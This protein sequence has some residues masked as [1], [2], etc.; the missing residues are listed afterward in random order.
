MSKTKLAFSVPGR[1]ALAI[2]ALP[3]LMGAARAQ[4]AEDFFKKAGRL[5]M[6]VS[7]D[8]GGG[9]EQIGRF[10]ASN[11]SRFL[12]GHPS[13]V[14]ENMPTAIGI[15][16]SNFFYNSAPR[17]GSAILADTNSALALPIFDS[18]AAHYDPR[19]FEWIGS[20]GK[21]QAICVT[22]KASE[23]VTLQDAAKRE[24]TVSTS[25]VNSGPGVYP[26]IL[27]SLLGTK[28]KVIAGYSPNA[29]ILAVDR[30]EVG[31]LC[32][33][34]WESFQ[35]RGSKWFVDK[36]VNVLAQIGISKSLDLPDVPLVE[37]LLKNPDDK[38]MLNLIVLPQEFGRPFVAPPGTPA[39]RM[40][41][42][43]RAFQAMVKDP[44]FLA[45]AKSQRIIIEPRDDKEIEAL[46]TQAYTAPK[47][48]H[49]RAAA[50]AAQMD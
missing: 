42:Y 39:D 16:A 27:N 9:Y 41:T 22:S 50:F 30:H 20:T 7:S 45:D 43:R 24:V 48:I 1:V 5:T 47:A 32:G 38:A 3:V 29:E 14:I 15:E 33:Y 13:F 36:S 2:I 19:R 4:S 21:Q 18:P 34:A 25:S 23:I 6:Y 8:A 49:D 46:L 12:P 40:A 31:G 35:A 26:T 28:F 37:D 44:Q 11:L 10:V 17:D